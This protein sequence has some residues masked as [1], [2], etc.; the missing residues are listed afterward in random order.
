MGKYDFATNKYIADLKIHDDKYFEHV[1]KFIGKYAEKKSYILDIGTGTGN[2]IKILR[3]KGYIN[4]FGLDLDSKAIIAGQNEFNLQNVIFDTENFPFRNKMFDVVISFTVGEHI[5]NISDFIDFKNS[6]LKDG[7]IFYMYMPNYHNPKFYLNVLITK[8]K[9]AEIHKTP[10]TIGNS[11]D[12]FLRFIKFSFLSVYKMLTGKVFIVKVTPL[13]SSVSEGGDADA[14]WCSNYLDLKNSFKRKKHLSYSEIE[15][16]S[17]KKSFSR[18]FFAA[19]VI[20]KNR[21]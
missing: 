19:K 3:E 5:D 4:S 10:F 17:I 12:I 14:T 2:L 20:F 16:P 13:P 1:I 9:G 7:G 15:P 11:L 8:L 6:F 18:E 21:I